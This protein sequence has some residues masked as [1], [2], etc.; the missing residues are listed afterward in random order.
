VTGATRALTLVVPG[1]IERRTGG[2]IYDRWVV[3]GLRGRGWR[4]DVIE[5]AGT[6]P[7]PNVHDETGAYEALQR[8]EPG[9]LAVVDGLALGAL[10]RASVECRAELVALVHHPLCDET[11]I[12]EGLRER[13]HAAERAALGGV[14]RIVVTS[15]F[16]CARLAELGLTRPGEH[17]VRVVEPGVA[18]LPLEPAPAPGEGEPLR[19]VSLGAVT[20]RKG[21]VD[22][23][24]A[25][26]EWPDLDV[27]WEHVGDLDADP[28]ET[29]RLRGALAD[30]GEAVASRVHL[31]GSVDDARVRAAL[32]RAH[33]FVHP[34]HYE[35]FGMAPREALAHGL[36]LLAS[37]GGALAE[38]VPE[39]AALRFDPGDVAGLA[40]WLVALAV[41]PL[42]QRAL[43]DAALEVRAQL[44]PW[45]QVAGDFAAALP[46]APEVRP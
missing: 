5:L 44:R 32:Q 28:D 23:A 9:S 36:P 17:D 12:D 13:L 39:A 41:D 6:F 15:E 29:A 25:L 42:L 40:G 27:E 3:E 11:G 16:T 46:P 7:T 45:D 18:D 2:T 31:A 8:L 33:A 24:R 14:S 4:V 35:G 30:A 21:Y 37:T 22:L 20:P 43:R 19:L 34:A 26:A 1:S 10:S 38:T